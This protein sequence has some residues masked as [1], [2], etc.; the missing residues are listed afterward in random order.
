MDLQTPLA[1]I[2]T[3]AIQSVGQNDVFSDFSHL[4]A[5]QS[6]HHIPVVNNNLKPVGI[7]STHD[8]N[9][10]KHH[11]SNM[12]WS[13]EQSQ[14]ENDRLFQSLLAK[15]I[16]VENPICLHEDAPVK[17]AIKLF[18]ENKIHSTI[19]C[20]DSGQCVGIVTPYDILKF[21]YHK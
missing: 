16:M 12:D 9:T 10:L 21:I 6:I 17:D 13:K 11:F 8:Y 19:I 2:M 1:K 20:N 18:L 3:K 14:M 7:I 5:S 4:F 15:D